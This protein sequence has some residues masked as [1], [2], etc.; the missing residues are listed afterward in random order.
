M[1]T[2]EQ[3]TIA[4]IYSECQALLENDKPEFL[5]LLERHIKLEEIIPLSFYLHF[6]AW[7]GRPREYP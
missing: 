2:K 4:D 7:K 3:I 5:T 1:I 6:N